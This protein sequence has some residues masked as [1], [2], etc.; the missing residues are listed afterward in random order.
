MKN[1]VFFSENIDAM[2]SLVLFQHY[3]LLKRYIMQVT[4]FVFCFDVTEYFL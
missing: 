1:S 2:E 3:F 4:D